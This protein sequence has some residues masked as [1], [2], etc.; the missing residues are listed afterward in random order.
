MYGEKLELFVRVL[1]QCKNN[2]NK[3]Y[4][5]HEPQTL[6]IAKGKSHKKYEFGSK[7]CFV[8]GKNK[9]V[10]LWAKKFDPNL[11]D[12]DT[13][14]E[15]VK[16][17]EGILCYKPDLGIADN[18]FR[19][20]KEIFGVKILTPANQCSKLRDSEKR[21]TR[22]RNKRGSV[23]ELVIGHLK[24]DFR[25]ARNILKSTLGDAI[26]ALM[27]AAAFNFKRWIRRERVCFLI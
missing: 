2:K 12:G 23:I 27:A 4:S 7:V 19:G 11:Y 25:M 8:T 14:E 9:C 15:T 21:G 26:N 24:S 22:K 20:R 5:L 3:I 1:L 16:Q 18:V 13:V 10:I 17:M 6:C